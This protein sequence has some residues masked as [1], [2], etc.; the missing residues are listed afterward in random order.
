MSITIPKNI[1]QMGEPEEKRKIYVEDYVVTY[2]KQYAKEE[3]LNSRGAVLLGDAQEQEGVS[4]LFIRSALELAEHAVADGTV[5]FTEELWGQVYEEIGKYFQGQEILGWFLS[6][7]GFSPEISYEILS[8]HRNYFPGQDKVLFMEDPTEGE[9]TFFAMSQGSLVR[10]KGYFIFY[11]RNL[12]MQQYML[13]K[14]GGKSVDN[15]EEFT[16]RAARSFRMLVQERK[17]QSDQ[18][19]LMAFLYGASTFLVMVV[20]VIGITM[21]NNYE[22]MEQ[23]EMALTNL[24]Q[25]L[26]NQQETAQAD[27]GEGQA[28]PEDLSSLVL[29][30][31]PENSSGQTLGET[32]NP[33]APEGTDLDGATDTEAP[34]GETGT[35]G[36]DTAGDAGTGGA[37]TAGEAGTAGEI[38]DGSGVEQPEPAPESSPQ[39]GGAQG[40][41]DQMQEVSAPA[42]SGTYIVQKGDTLLSISRRIYGNDRH[43]KEIC[44]LNNIEDS[45]KIYAGEKILLP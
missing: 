9:E 45:D 30:E 12:P 17:E 5:L 35:G 37:D 26:E 29:G 39:D 6:T 40:Q 1:R 28:S 41:P 21:I 3:I 31:Q 4:Y 22:K 11:E 24:T 10:Q 8:T 42:A 25:N 7:P 19:R 33:A 44:Q 32:G 27:I 18:K 14:R 2:L 13:E 23:V 43:I 20:L 38:P 34:T 16:D 36:A 15:R